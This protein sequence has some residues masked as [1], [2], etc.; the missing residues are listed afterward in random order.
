MRGGLRRWG[1]SSRS[2]G[3]KYTVRGGRLGP[4][5][6]LSVGKSVAGVWERQKERVSGGP[7]GWEGARDA[8][9]PPETT[10]LP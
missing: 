2:A 6:H 10:P 9:G 8:D 5:A 7:R 3:E 1:P 4:G